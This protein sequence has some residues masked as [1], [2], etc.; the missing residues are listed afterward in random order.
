MDNNIKVDYR[1]IENNIIIHVPHASVE[2]PKEI[3]NRFLVDK[4]YMGSEAIFMSD[5]LVDLFLPEDETDVLKFEYSRMFCDVERFKDDSKEKMS[6]VGMGAIY[7]KDS[8]GVEFIN[9]DNG[10]K[11]SIIKQ[12]YDEYHD[13]LTKLVDKKLEKFGNCLI[14]DLHSYS[15]EFVEKVLKI[16]N[17]PDICIGIEDNF[18]DDILTNVIK[19]HF[20]E[21]GYSVEINHP[22]N[23]SI[24]PLKY[25]GTDEKI[26][27]IMIEINKRTYLDGKFL[28]Y[29]KFN[30]LKE[31]MDELYTKIKAYCS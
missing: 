15:D 18:K 3:E 24:V 2:F 6:K 5:Y 20:I 23:G 31:V 30:R 29:K 12:Y 8:N 25:W 26:V 21:Y 11:E 22:Y 4:E 17:N 7:E 13:K 28:D 1:P 19:K 14:L 9:I 16:K 10:Y 27:S